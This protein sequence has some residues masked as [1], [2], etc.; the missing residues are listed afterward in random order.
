[1]SY[2]TQV[3]V[4]FRDGKS[5]TEEWNKW[6]NKWKTEFAIKHS[7]LM[8]LVRHNKHTETYTD[9]YDMVNLH[10]ISPSY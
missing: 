7:M 10:D 6:T 4:H 8:L 2:M 3:E 9:W 1:M 5:Q